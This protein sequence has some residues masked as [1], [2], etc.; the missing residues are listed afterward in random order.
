MRIPWPGPEIKKGGR[1]SEEN[2]EERCS[3]GATA[4]SHKDTHFRWRDY[5][6]A[7]FYISVKYT[8]SLDRISLEGTIKHSPSIK[9]G[10]S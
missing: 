6:D 1:G 9:T 3:S 4:L 5:S 8:K 7:V 10:M 2:K